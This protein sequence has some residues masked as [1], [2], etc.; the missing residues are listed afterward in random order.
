MFL[1][2][3]WIVPCY[4]PAKPDEASQNSDNI[5]VNVSYEISCLPCHKAAWGIAS[6]LMHGNVRPILLQYWENKEP[7]MKIFGPMPHDIEGKKIYREYMK[8]AST[9][10]VPGIIWGSYTLS[11]WIQSLWM[12]PSH[13][14]RYLCASF[15]WGNKLRGIFIFHSRERYPKFEKHSAS[16]AQ[17]SICTIQSSSAASDIV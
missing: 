2:V 14:F 16:L 15:L 3:T 4:P 9:A 12:C 7:A 6:D 1:S 10:S 8:A 17:K 5:W 13:H 11:N